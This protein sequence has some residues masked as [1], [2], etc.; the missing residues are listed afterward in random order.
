VT[1]PVLSVAGA[2]VADARVTHLD[3]R[4]VVVVVVVVVVRRAPVG[5]A[6]C[7]FIVIIVVVILLGVSF[8]RAVCP[9]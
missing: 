2:L 6:A 9:S 7:A 3:A 8:E 1:T 5:I 4:A